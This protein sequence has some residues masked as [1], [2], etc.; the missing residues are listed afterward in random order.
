[1]A[2]LP[3]KKESIKQT[4]FRE[5]SKIFVGDKKKKRKKKEKRKRVQLLSSHEKRIMICEPSMARTPREIKPLQWSRGWVDTSINACLCL[6]DW[7]QTFANCYGTC[8]CTFL[9]WNVPLLCVNNN[10]HLFPIVIAKRSHQ[11]EKFIPTKNCSILFLR[12]LFRIFLILCEVRV[13]FAGII[14]NY[15]P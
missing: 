10:S 8:L 6:S 3:A 5:M 15:Q 9:S 14:K 11:K 13:E 12:N 2:L 1:L 7:C 4:P